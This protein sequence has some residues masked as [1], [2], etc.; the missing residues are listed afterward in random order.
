VEN[1]QTVEKKGLRRN[2]HA[3]IILELRTTTVGELKIGDTYSRA[4]IMGNSGETQYVQLPTP[5]PPP[6]L[7][8]VRERGTGGKEK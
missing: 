1:V 8:A 2:T 7:P 4:A 3:V 5:P 6:R